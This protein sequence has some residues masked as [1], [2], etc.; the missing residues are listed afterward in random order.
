MKGFEVDYEKRLADLIERRTAPVELPTATKM[1]A[2]GRPIQYYRASPIYEVYDRIGDEGSA[3]RYTVGAMA[4]VDPK[5]TEVTY[6]EGN[7][8]KKQLAVAY[9]QAYAECDFEYQ[10]SVTTDTH[11]KSYS[12]IDLLAITQRFSTLEPPQRPKYP[13]EGD[14]VQDLQEVRSVSVEKLRAAYPTARVD[15]SGRKSVE[16]SGGT[17]KRKVDVVP[18]NWYDTNE[19]AQTMA[20]RYRAIQV[21]DIKSG[22]RIKNSPFLHG[23]KIEMLDRNTNGGL[24]KLI[25][26]M[27]SL[28]YDSG[29][30]SLSSYD[31]TAIG[32]NMPQLQLFTSPGEEIALLARLKSYLDSLVVNDEYRENMI[33][34]DES[35]RVFC[36]GH[37][38]VQGLDE[39]RDEVDDLIEAVCSN[40]Q[41]SFAK[42]AEARVVY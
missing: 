30:V 15:D 21:L 14:P 34:P 33:V 39:L 18:A 41:K 38:T 10:G 37:A 7:R 9:R 12:D 24:R 17:L 27:K 5:Y 25:R 2:I 1:A 4:R 20:K 35:R 31:L 8:V 23:Y 40:R 6:D 11:I 36:D 13:Y 16:I 26:L 42:L 22:E 32:F 19:Y 3:V 29:H 28:K